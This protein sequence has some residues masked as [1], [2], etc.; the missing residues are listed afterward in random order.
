MHWG[1]EFSGAATTTVY[2]TQWLKA[3][4]KEVFYALKSFQN[5]WL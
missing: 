2:V 3:N 1:R 5:F 4:G